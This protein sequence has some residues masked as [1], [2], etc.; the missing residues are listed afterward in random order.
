[1]SPPP[2][3][4]GVE[5]SPKQGETT[6]TALVEED[7]GNMTCQVSESQGLA[8]ELPWGSSFVWRRDSTFRM[9][10]GAI[11][12]VLLVY[13]GTLFVYR[14][15]F[16]DFHVQ[17]PSE[18]LEHIA[19]KERSRAWEGIDIV[20]T[21]FFWLDLFL[22]F[23]FSYDDEKGTEVIDLRRVC[24]HYLSTYFVLNLAACVPESLV[25]AIINASTPQNDQYS[26]NMNQG[27]RALRLQRI[28]LQRLA[29]LS[30]L[31]RLLRLGKTRETRRIWRRFLN[32]KGVRIANLLMWLLW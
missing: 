18:P 19:V 21:V 32:S 4:Q 3:E 11:V 10:W 23:F 13:T 22:C 9:L 29:K 26:L 20:V 5:H 2:A 24:M 8:D 1:M 15:A 16:I 30:K 27:L 6:P 12:T 7:S 31:S 17:S 28:R 25:E 14:L